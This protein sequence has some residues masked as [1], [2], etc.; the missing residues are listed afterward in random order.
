MI[1]TN[2]NHF[3]WRRGLVLGTVL[4]ITTS[5]MVAAQGPE[6]IERGN[7]VTENVPDVPDA[8]RERLRQYQNIRPASFVDWSQ[9]GENLLISTRFGETSQFHLVEQPLGARQQLT[10]YDE[11]ARGGDWAPEGGPNGFLFT[12]DVGGAEVFRL[13]YFDMDTGAV[14]ILSS[15]GARVEAYSWSDDGSMIMWNETTTDSPVRRTFMASSTATDKPEQVFEGE[16][17]WLPAGLSPDNK[18]LLLFNYVSR[19]EST[20][21]LLDLK[22]KESTQI[23]PSNEKI[24]YGSVFFSGDGKAL[25]YV[26]DEGSEFQQLTRYELGSNKK[27]VLTGDIPWDVQGASLSPDGKLLVFTTNEGGLSKLHIRE[28]ATNTPVPAP[29]LPPGLVVGVGFSPDSQKIGFTLNSAS[30]PS[31]TYVYDL[32]SKALTRWTKGEVG[33]LDTDGFVNPTLVRFPTFDEVDGKAR[34]IP[35]FLFKPQ[36]AEGAVPVLISIHGGPE[37]QYRPSFNAFFQY[38]TNELGIAVLAPNVRGSAGYGKSYLQLDNGFKREDSVKD[39]GAALDWIATRDDLD[40]DKVIVFGGSYGGYMVLAS[41]VNY[42]DRLAGGVDIVGISNFVTFLENTSPYRQDLRRS[43]YGDERDPEMRAHLEKI[44]PLNNVDKIRKPLFIIQGL[45]DPRVPV[46]ESEQMLDA[47]R[48]NGG[49]VWYLL[50]K[51][52]GHG[53]RKK[54]NRDYLLETTVLFLEDVLDLK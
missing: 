26:A 6:R 15:E 45:N 18:Q 12:K 8:P 22:S 32:T 52:E 23:N 4:L 44:S 19:N 9:D 43:E 51:D 2:S 7:I 48:A 47:V 35:A 11:P 42:N 14:R 50:A 10:F 27:T 28:P 41:M 30:A 53:F 54:S 1:K 46:T 5:P 20:I 25:Y 24:A 33:G 49:K 3:A 16:G 39:I 38:L 17:Y 21:H 37:G 13:H 36:E 31:D 34:E 29:D 40:Q